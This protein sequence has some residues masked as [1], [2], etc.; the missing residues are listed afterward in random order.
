MMLPDPANSPGDKIQAV[1][2]N[3][4]SIFI[5]RSINCF[6][7]NWVEQ[8]FT[9]VGKEVQSISRN[10]TSKTPNLEEVASNCLYE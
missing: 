4:N 8:T 2:C 9:F 6:V 5:K 7:Y 1:S 3:Q 10:V